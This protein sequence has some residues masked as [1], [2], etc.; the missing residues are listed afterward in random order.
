MDCW[1]GN[2]S[3]GYKALFD[4]AQLMEQH[5]AKILPQKDKMSK[6]G[7][8][9]TLTLP[10]LTL[11][12][13][14]LYT[15]FGSFATG[16]T[17]LAIHHKLNQIRSPNNTNKN[18]YFKEYGKTSQSIIQILTFLQSSINIYGATSHPTSI[19][20]T[21]AAILLCPVLIVIKTPKTLILTILIV[22]LI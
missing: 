22:Y 3:N 6:L 21:N 15:N 12:T 16:N 17:W 18:F 11:Q 10:T 8:V 19:L 4:S 7:F 20:T 1:G 9:V 14:T 2:E 13:L 5:K